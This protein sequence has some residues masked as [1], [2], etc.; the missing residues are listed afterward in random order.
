MTFKFTRADVITAFLI[1]LCLPLYYKIRFLLEGIISWKEIISPSVW[2]EYAFAAILGFGLVKI[3]GAFRYTTG[4]GLTIT[5]IVGA[6]AATAFTWFFY[7]VIFPYGVQGSFLFDIVILS[8]FV[9]LLISGVGDRIL[10]G[11]RALRAEKSAL[12]ARFE[13][14]KSRL[15]PH[16][17]FNSLSTLSDIVEDDPVLAVRFIDRMSMIYRYILENEGEASVGLNEEIEAAQALLF[18]L[19]TRHPGALTISSILPEQAT[20]FYTAPLVVQSLVEN[21]LKHNHYTPNSPLTVTIRIEG[22]DLLV[23]NTLNSATKT[24]S[25]KSGLQTLK[26]RLQMLTGRELRYGKS[27]R[28]FWVRVPLLTESHP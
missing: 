13:T 14:L 25:L 6:L 1:T 16:F 2:I 27:E 5:A 18:V 22:D 8:L 7:T 4:L 26:E 28:T 10:L 21:A 23:E 17:L 9:P 3:H 11:D 19:E 12:E 20:G 15:S 24:P